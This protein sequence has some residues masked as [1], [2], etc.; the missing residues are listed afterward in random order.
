MRTFDKLL[1][2]KTMINLNTV[3]S[4]HF[5]STIYQ[6]LLNEI[7]LIVHLIQLLND[8]NVIQF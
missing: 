1:L 4:F 7:V 8:I 3:Q 2:F 6:K 5:K